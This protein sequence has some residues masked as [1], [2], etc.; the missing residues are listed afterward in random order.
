MVEEEV[1]VGG[2]FRLGIQDAGQSIEPIETVLCTTIDK[3]ILLGL[4]KST[5]LI[6]YGHYFL[7]ISNKEKEGIEEGVMALAKKDPV[8]GVRFSRAFC[9][10]N[11]TGL[12]QSIPLNA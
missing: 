1:R 2:I 4:A 9:P 6:W 7:Y 10:G 3:I 11:V 8:S 12:L 5:V